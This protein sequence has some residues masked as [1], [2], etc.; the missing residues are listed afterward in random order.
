MSSEYILK[1][2]AD[3]S[4]KSFM[5]IYRNTR[6]RI[7]EDHS[8]RTSDLSHDPKFVRLSNFSLK[9]K[10][11]SKVVVQGLVFVAHPLYKVSVFLHVITVTANVKEQ[12]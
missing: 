2:E 8:L 4:S 1:K 5:P 6:Y 11:S 10:R 7:P 3:D 12:I 9:H